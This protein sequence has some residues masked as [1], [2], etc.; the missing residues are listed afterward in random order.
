[1]TRVKD[2]RL[3]GGRLCLDFVNTADWQ[4]LDVVVEHIETPDQLVQWARR[5]R[6]AASE[7]APGKSDEAGGQLNEIR[8][9]RL[10]LRRLVRGVIAAATPVDCDVRILND[11]LDDAE[12]LPRVRAERGGLAYVPGNTI[13]AALQGP[14]AVSALELL[15]S[16]DRTRIKECGG[17]RCGWLFVD[18]SRN[19][20][21]RW[22]SM[23]VCGNRWKAR[24]HY[25][26]A[27]SGDST[28]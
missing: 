9:F 23:D 8:A 12:S 10:R 1:M 11:L 13:T 26:R 14:I 16:P 28:T 6:L 15:T 18:E 24:R 25:A 27:T 19:Q 2:L 3:V 5:M 4:G 22:C 21:R 7:K 20:T 17:C